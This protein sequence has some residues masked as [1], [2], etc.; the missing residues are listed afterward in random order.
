MVEVGGDN[1]MSSFVR[2]DERRNFGTR[3]QASVSWAP[4]LSHEPLTA[5]GFSC[6]TELSGLDDFEVGVESRQ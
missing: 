2:S 1:N 4:E 5:R 3:L 6:A